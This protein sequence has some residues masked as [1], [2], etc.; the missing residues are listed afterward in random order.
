MTLVEIEGS[1]L[2]D[3]PKL[4]TD[5][6]FRTQ[7]VTQL[8]PETHQVL[9]EFWTREFDQY[10]D[11]LRNEAIAPILNKVGQ[12][13]GSPTIRQILKNPKSSIDLESMMNQGKIVL[14][15]L[16][17]GRLGED[18]ATLLGAMFIT[19][20]QLAA[21]NRINIPE[22]QRKD[23]FSTSTSFKTLLPPPL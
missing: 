23:F 5:K 10:G 21:M 11:K 16:S 14:L 2:L 22:E 8:N 3:I 18:N 19:Q 12:F 9:I 13:I 20:F 17:Q 4:L 1:T 6:N 15:N 7:L